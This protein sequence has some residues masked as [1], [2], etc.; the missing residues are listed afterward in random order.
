MENSGGSWM[1]GERGALV[2]R[3]QSCPEGDLGKAFGILQLFTCQRRERCSCARSPPIP[4]A[5]HSLFSLL[6]ATV[7]SGFSRRLFLVGFG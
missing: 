3:L 2:P 1:W 6:L 4:A 7:G 5:P